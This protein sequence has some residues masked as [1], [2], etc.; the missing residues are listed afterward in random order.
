MLGSGLER[1]HS[2]AYSPDGTRIAAGRS[3]DVTIFDLE[4]GMPEVQVDGECTELAYA[5]DGS[6]IAIGRTA[7]VH[8]ISLPDA[9]P[10]GVLTGHDLPV[11]G[12]AYSPD[13]SRIATSALDQVVRIWDRDHLDAVAVLRENT[14][15]IRAIAWSRDGTTLAS[16]ASDRTLQLWRSVRPRGFHQT[17]RARILVRPTTESMVDAL[18]ERGLSRADVLREVAAQGGLSA[19]ARDVAIRR[20]H[21]REH[22]NKEGATP[23]PT[24]AMLCRPKL[25]AD[26]RSQTQAWLDSNAGPD[27]RHQEQS[28][29]ALSLLRC[30]R[31][32]ESLALIQTCFAPR[33][34]AQLHTHPPAL[35]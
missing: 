35:G 30:D 16:A 2:L 5:P 22:R 31:P 1:I 18:Y 10:R 3:R 4:T 17:I 13:G 8:L 25:T 6:E 29:R 9:T 33:G 21:A 32:Q 28:R 11:T 27:D 12:V 7:E 26:E 14:S 34:A 20:A 24:W 19:A 23:R 15:W